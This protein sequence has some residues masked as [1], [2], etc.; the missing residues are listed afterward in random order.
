MPSIVNDNKNKNINEYFISPFQQSN[1]IYF[2]QF[3]PVYKSQRF[4]ASL[5]WKQTL[6]K[7]SGRGFIGLSSEY[8]ADNMWALKSK[9]MFGGS[10]ILYDL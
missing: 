1:K 3:L 8:K 4:R 10:M 5:I 9:A 6:K 7:N 2:S